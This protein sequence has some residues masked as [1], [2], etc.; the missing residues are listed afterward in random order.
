MVKGTKGIIDAEMPT[1][2]ANIAAVIDTAE[3]SLRALMAG[4]PENKINK[5]IKSVELTEKLAKKA[6]K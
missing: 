6:G 3:V 5:V 2:E 4:Q 1:A